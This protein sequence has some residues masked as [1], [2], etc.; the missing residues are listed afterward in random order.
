[1]NKLY[2]AKEI[3]KKCRWYLSK[4]LNIYEDKGIK[5]PVLFY[6]DIKDNTWR[7]YSNKELVTLEELYKLF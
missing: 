4:C 3:D 1:M 6:L 2:E 5:T 7:W